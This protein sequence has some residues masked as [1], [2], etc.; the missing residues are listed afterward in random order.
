MNKKIVRGGLAGV[1]VLAL[2]AG[3]S[4]FAS[5]SD[6]DQINGNETEAGHLKLDLNSTGSINNVGGNA[7]A[8]GQYA[9]HRLHGGQRRP[10]RCARRRPQHEDPQPGGQGQRLRLDQR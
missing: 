2:A 7:I 5:W 10:R 4:T 9:D 3:G 1:A 8:P 6:Y